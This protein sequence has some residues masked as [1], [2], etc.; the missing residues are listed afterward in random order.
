MLKRDLKRM[1]GSRKV[2]D[3]FDPGAPMVVTTGRMTR[4]SGEWWYV[5]VYGGMVVYGL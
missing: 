1:S 4:T 3:Q 2:R 5:V